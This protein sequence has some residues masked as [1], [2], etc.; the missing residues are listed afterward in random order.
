M[1]A[2]KTPEGRARALAKRRDTERVRSIAELREEI[3]RAGMHVKW[4]EPAD[5]RDMAV[6]ARI[7]RLAGS[8][9][10]AEALDDETCRRLENIADALV[11]ADKPLHFGAAFNNNGTLCYR[12]M[13]VPMSAEGVQQLWEAI[14]VREIAATKEEQRRRGEAA[15]DVVRV[16]FQLGRRLEDP[17]K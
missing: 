14:R 1:S 16:D 11:W 6:V 12:A 7:I 9:L 15:N 5:R 4:S 13:A 2:P 10:S 8:L 17:S 3:D